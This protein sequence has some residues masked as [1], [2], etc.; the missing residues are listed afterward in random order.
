MWYWLLLYNLFLIERPPTN[1][2]ENN[3]EEVMAKIV[4]KYVLFL[5]ILSISILCLTNNTR[6]GTWFWDNPDPY[7]GIK[8][9]GYAALA[10]IGSDYVLASLQ[11]DAPDVMIGAD[12]V[13]IYDIPRYSNVSVTYSLIGEATSLYGASLHFRASIG[14]QGFYSIYGP[15][16]GVWENFYGQET[17]YEYWSKPVN[18][19]H[20]TW[21]Y[22]D[23]EWTKYWSDYY[24]RMMV[25]LSASVRGMTY[26][27]GYD[28]D[29]FYSATMYADPV[30]KVNG[31]A[32][33][34]IG[35]YVDFTS[36]SESRGT[37]DNPLEPVPEPATVLLIG[38]GL[39]GFAGFRRRF[40]KI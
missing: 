10:D 3:K 8:D 36:R 29:A 20:Q 17:I 19:R 30:I 11:G 15:S 33:D 24:D 28:P 32:I 21:D 4:R 9:G 5:S 27:P 35:G 40:K 39:V 7:T 25:T 12:L 14:F 37:F 16:T 34:P 26:G 2:T 23:Q 13:Y 38:S 22:S 31:N 18:D 6:A 1:L